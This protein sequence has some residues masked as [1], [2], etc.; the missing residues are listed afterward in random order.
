[1]ARVRCN[2]TLPDKLISQILIR[3][4]VK[5]LLQYQSVSKTWL[6]MIKNPSFVKSQLRHALTTQTDDQTLLKAYRSSVLHLDS[7]RNVAYLKFPFP[8]RDDVMYLNLV[9]SA[10]GIVCVSVEFGSHDDYRNTSICLWNPATTQS[11]FVPSSFNASVDC[12]L[13]RQL[14]GVFGE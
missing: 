12:C 1:M 7:G 14:C 2:P 13:C 9:G 11:K 8:R 5:S 10:N 3:V 4:P 6:S